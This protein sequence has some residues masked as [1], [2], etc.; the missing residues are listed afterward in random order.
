MKIPVTAMNDIR[1]EVDDDLLVK[2][3]DSGPGYQ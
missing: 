3:D 2:Q 1:L